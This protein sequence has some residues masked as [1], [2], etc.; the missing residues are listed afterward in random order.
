MRM[1]PLINQKN[2]PAVMRAFLFMENNEFDRKYG[3]YLRL[4]IITQNEYNSIKK[5]YESSALENYVEIP[6]KLPILYEITITKARNSGIK[7]TDDPQ[8]QIAFLNKL[9]LAKFAHHEK[10]SKIEFRVATIYTTHLQ[11]RLKTCG[12]TEPD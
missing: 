8:Q 7:I 9:S 4:G 2:K 6:S 3:K 12:W 5:F 10:P 1:V 11:A